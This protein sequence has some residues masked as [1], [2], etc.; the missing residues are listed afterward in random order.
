MGVS[1]KRFGAAASLEPDT[2]LRGEDYC[3]ANAWTP[4]SPPPEYMMIS[5]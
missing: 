3:V 2:A 1:A 4:I 5:I